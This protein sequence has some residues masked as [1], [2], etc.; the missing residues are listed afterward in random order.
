LTN[1]DLDIKLADRVKNE[2]IR[3]H[4][5]S[6]KLL[7][8]EAHRLQEHCGPKWL[9]RSRFLDRHSYSFSLRRKTTVCQKDPKDLIPK[10][11]D[12]ILFVKRV[13]TVNQHLLSDIV[14]GVR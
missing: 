7:R 1:P 2:R 11:F 4:P 14:C 10:F 12:F 9:Q 5:V 3:K 8:T 13:T 6:I